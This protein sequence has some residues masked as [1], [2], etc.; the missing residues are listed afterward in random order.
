MAD[1]MVRRCAADARQTRQPDEGRL[2]RDPA[3]ASRGQ[4]ASASSGVGRSGPSRLDITQSRVRMRVRVAGRT[5]SGIDDRHRREPQVAA[6]RA[7]E[8]ADRRRRD[9]AVGRPADQ[10]QRREH[11]EAHRVAGLATG[12]QL[13]LLGPEPGPQLGH[14]SSGRLAAELVGQ[15]GHLGHVAVGVDR[16]DGAGAVA[17]VGRAG[18]SRP[19]CGAPTSAGGGRWPRSGDRRAR[20]PCTRPCTRLTMAMASRASAVEP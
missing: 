1:H 9:H 12:A 10:R 16:A 18:T 14:R 15:H 4:A 8:Q 17:P 2:D 11:E 5:T 7:G 20:C 6:H 3:P 19:A 13:G